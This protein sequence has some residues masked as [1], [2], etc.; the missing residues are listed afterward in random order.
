MSA[1]STVC[2][3]AT[4]AACSAKKTKKE[5]EADSATDTSGDLQ[6][7]RERYS[8]II[9]GSDI[10]KVKR[11]ANQQEQDTSHCLAHFVLMATHR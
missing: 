3:A 8:R 7:A 4:T 9:A 10:C 1:A 11:D 2:L 5:T 6:A